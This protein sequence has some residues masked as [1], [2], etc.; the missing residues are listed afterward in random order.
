MAAIPP[1][2]AFALMPSQAFAGGLIDYGTREGLALF[3]R[4]TRSM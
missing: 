3:G 1:Q 2:P 4:N